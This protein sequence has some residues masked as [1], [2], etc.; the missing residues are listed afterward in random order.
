MDKTTWSLASESCSSFILCICAHNGSMLNIWS[1]RIRNSW[2]VQ[3]S[4]YIHGW[5]FRLR[6]DSTFLSF[7]PNPVSWLSFLYYSLYVWLCVTS[8]ADIHQISMVKPLCSCIR[9]ISWYDGKI[10]TSLC[11]RLMD[12]FHLL[13]VVFFGKHLKTSY[14]L[15]FGRTRSRLSLPARRHIIR[16]YRNLARNIHACKALK[17]P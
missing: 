9:L 11:C 13:R 3:I 14:D 15:F 17:M 1:L 2:L 7:V 4:P 10:S 8:S 12:N 16:S 5:R 6:I